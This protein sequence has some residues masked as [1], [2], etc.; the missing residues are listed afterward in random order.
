MWLCFLTR[1]RNGLGK[2][3]RDI[4]RRDRSEMYIVRRMPIGLERK[5]RPGIRPFSE[6]IA[7]ARAKE[8][9]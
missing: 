7:L 4:L 6:Y 1:T 5:T 3:L 8:S 9:V 2:K